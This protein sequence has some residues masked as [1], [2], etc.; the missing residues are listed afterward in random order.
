MELCQTPTA[1]RTCNQ[2]R[3][4]TNTARSGAQKSKWSSVKENTHV[5]TSRL[6]KHLHGE[7]QPARHQHAVSGNVRALYLHDALRTIHL[8]TR[9]QSPLKTR[10]SNAR[11]H[12]NKHTLDDR[13]QVRGLREEVGRRGLRC[14][15]YTPLLLYFMSEGPNGGKR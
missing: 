1:R 8:D 2:G 13:Y 7:I 6:G 5:P 12:A 9:D 3:K 14:T 11:S 4:E 15:S 10:A